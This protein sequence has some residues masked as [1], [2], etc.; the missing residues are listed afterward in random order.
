MVRAGCKALDVPH[1]PMYDTSEALLDPQAMHL[2]LT[3][4]GRTPA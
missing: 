2:Q 3:A 1:A 4:S